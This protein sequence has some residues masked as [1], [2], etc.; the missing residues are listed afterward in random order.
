MSNSFAVLF[1][2]ELY[3]D[4]MFLVFLSPINKLF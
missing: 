1:I 4:L 2:I 3:F